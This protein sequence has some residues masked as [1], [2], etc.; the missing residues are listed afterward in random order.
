MRFKASIKLIPDF[1]CSKCGK[2]KQ[3]TDTVYLEAESMEEMNRLVT[4]SINQPPAAGIP[5]GWVSNGSAGTCCN[6]C[7]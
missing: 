2:V 7:N 3:G 6:E 4:K 1:T 5:I